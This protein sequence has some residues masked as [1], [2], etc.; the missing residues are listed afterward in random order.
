M[1]MPDRTRIDGFRT[2]S[3]TIRAL[4]LKGLYFEAIAATY[5]AFFQKQGLLGWGLKRSTRWPRALGWSCLALEEGFLR[6]LGHS[7]E[8]APLSLCFDDRGMYYDA[9]GPSRLEALVLR[10]VVDDAQRAR[11]QRIQ[12]AWIHARASKYNHAPE[13]APSDRPR[14][15]VLVVDQTVGDLSVSGGIATARSFMRMLEAAIHENPG[16]EIVVKTHPQVLAGRKRGY[17]TSP[18]LARFPRVTIL[19]Q[20]IHLPSLLEHARV[21]YTVTSQ[22]GFEA[23]LWRKPVRIFGMPF[24]AGWGLT[25]DELKRPSRRAARTLDDL[26]HAALLE[27]PVYV[28]PRARQIT[29]VENI[30]ELIGNHRKT[31]G[32]Q[33]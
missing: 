28:N 23:L 14:D 1:H 20:D 12:A 30:L 16:C 4:P 11:A 17:L 15:H 10:G 33:A 29:N 24:Y 32:L 13:F 19:G 5:P 9:S 3:P 27:Y 18:S 21:V 8:E 22:V 7:A 6:G 2:F 26:S 31:S 25:S